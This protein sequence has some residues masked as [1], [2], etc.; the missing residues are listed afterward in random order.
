LPRQ[1]A[2]SVPDVSTISELRLVLIKIIDQ[3]SERIAQS[4]RR[5]ED[6]NMGQ[7]RITSM[8][9]ASADQ[10][11]ITLKQL[12]DAVAKVSKASGR[13]I[14]AMPSSRGLLSAIP[15]APGPAGAVY[16]ATDYQHTYYWTGSAWIYAPGDDGS[17]FISMYTEVPNTGFWQVCD[18]S[19]VTR[20]KTNGTTASVTVPNLITGVYPKF[21]SPYT[22]NNVAQILPV[23]GLPSSTFNVG[24]GAG[25]NVASN[26]HIHTVTNTPEPI[27]II[28]LPYYRL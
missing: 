10:D 23:I 16:Y 4:S 26:A 2:Y 11:A 27:N 15:G 6:M 1:E 20:S 12:N 8:A 14:S 5:T 18:G 28:L 24:S 17:G 7:N 3:I 21:G 9:D 25:A 13:A 19:T 22:G